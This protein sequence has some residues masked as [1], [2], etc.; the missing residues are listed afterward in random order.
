MP[1]GLRLRCFGGHIVMVV[2]TRS[3]RLLCYSWLR[4]DRLRKCH[5]LGYDTLLYHGWLDYTLG[6]NMLLSPSCLRQQRLGYHR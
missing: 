4:H 1:A 5:G 2:H 3:S 6:Y